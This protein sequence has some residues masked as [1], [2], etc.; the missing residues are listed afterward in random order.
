M[1]SERSRARAA[2]RKADLYQI[3]TALETYYADNG[4]YPQSKIIQI[5]PKITYLD[6][7]QTDPGNSPCPGSYKWINNVGYPKRYC[8]YTCLENGKYFAV[9]HIGSNR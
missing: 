6:P 5:L 4:S 8:V 1:K 9:S 7:F 3:R 2:R